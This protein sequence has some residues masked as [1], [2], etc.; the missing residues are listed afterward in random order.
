MKK[1]KKVYVEITNICNLSCHFCS[2]S[3]RKQ[4]YM[5]LDSFERILNEIKPFTDYIY[6]HVKGEPLLHP[7]LEE[8]LDLAHSRGFRVNITTNGSFI[9]GIG[10]SLLTKP[11]L[12]Q[13]NFSLHS[14]GENPENIH[15]NNYLRDILFF[16]KKALKNTDIIVSLR[17]WNYD[18]KVKDETQKGNNEILQILEKEFKLDYK[19]SHILNP[20]KGLKIT[21]RLYLNSDYQF[22]WPDTD[23]TYEDAAGFCY[24]MRTHT[25][26]LVDGTV[27]PCCLDGEG[28]INLGNI[29]NESFRNIINSEKAKAIYN[30]FS[31]KTAVE[32]LCKKCQFKI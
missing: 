14:F 5:K 30:G 16:S 3:K 31:E 26:I 17:L 1:F 15:K 23:D 10:E 25:A 32:K 21:D 11:A 8:F 20:G 13:I 27:V 12:R 18:K 4:E 28:T 6:L 29:F 7:Q 22:K 19:I 2:K 24:G 9:G